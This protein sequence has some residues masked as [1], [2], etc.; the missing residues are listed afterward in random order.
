M[1]LPEPQKI[2]KRKDIPSFDEFKA[3][4]DARDRWRYVAIFIDSQFSYRDMGCYI[5]L[6]RG[7]TIT[8][9]RATTI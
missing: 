6:Y 3:A 2:K 1:E 4:M 7:G 8:L 9:G 5:D